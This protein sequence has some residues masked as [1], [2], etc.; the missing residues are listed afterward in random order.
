MTTPIELESDTILAEI[1]KQSPIYVRDNV[2]NPSE[3]MFLL[4]KNAMLIGSSIA[5][6][7]I[8]AEFQEN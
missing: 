5:L 8:Q 4:I 6:R 2:R 7:V 1:D 3:D